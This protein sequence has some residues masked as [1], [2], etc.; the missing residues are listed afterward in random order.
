MFLCKYNWKLLDYAVW[1]IPELLKQAGAKNEN[2]ITAFDIYKISTKNH[3]S[4][5]Y[6]NLQ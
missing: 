2:E 5:G 6:S 3:T 1:F 4:V